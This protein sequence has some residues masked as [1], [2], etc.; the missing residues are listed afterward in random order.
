MQAD[1]QRACTSVRA[2]TFA[3]PRRFDFAAVAAIDPALR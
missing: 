2:V 3:Q 1:K